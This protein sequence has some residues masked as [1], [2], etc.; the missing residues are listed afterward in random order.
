MDTT[1][2]ATYYIIP[3]GA[4]Q[5]EACTWPELENACQM[6]RLSPDTLIYL[7]DKDV[8]EKAIYTDLR[9]YFRDKEDNQDTSAAEDD[10]DKLEM[11]RGSYEEAREEARRTP[12]SSQAHLNAAHAAMAMDNREAAGEHCQHAITLQPFNPK[13]AGEIKRILGPVDTRRLRFIERPDPFWE[14][15]IQL[16]TFPVGRGIAVFFIPAA[17]VV[18]LALFSFLRVPAAVICFLWTYATILQVASGRRGPLGFEQVFSASAARM[19]KPL[20]IGMAVF[21]ELYLPFVIVAEIFILAGISDSSNLI[22]LIQHNEAIIVFLWVAGVVYLPAAFA[23]AASPDADWKKCMDVRNVYKAVITME[24]EYLAT[25]V[26]LFV[27]VTVWGAGRLF[28][29]QVP[30][31][32]IIVP[33]VVGLYGLG[34]SGFV[35]GLLSARYRHIWTKGAA[36]KQESSRVDTQ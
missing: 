28:L 26:L 21:A 2:D 1:K 8:W 9:P 33:V 25:V 19:I 29:A 5:E 14:D 30:A 24:M 31:V 12:D 6:G 20:S 36:C 10:G 15:L 17:I 3:Q 32:G 11:L 23:I 34:I 7:P 4:T 16:A 22:Q 35:I 13:I 18:S 27:P